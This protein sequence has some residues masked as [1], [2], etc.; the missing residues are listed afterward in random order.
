MSVSV[1]TVKPVPAA[2]LLSIF[3]PSWGKNE[4][5][6]T[7]EGAFALEGNAPDLRPSGKI[8]LKDICLPRFNLA[9]LSGTVNMPLVKEGQPQNLLG[10][11]ELP[12]MKLGGTHAEKLE[13]KL[14]IEMIGERKQEA[15]LKISDGHFQLAG[16]D[17][18]WTGVADL[19]HRMLALKGSFDKLRAADISEQLFTRAGE[20][21]GTLKGTFDLNT[22]GKTNREAIA[23]LNGKAEF[24]VENG[25]LARFGHLQ[26]ELTRVNLLHQGLFGFNLNNLLQSV[27][28]VRTGLFKEI[29]GNMRMDKGILTVEYLKYNADDMCLWAGGKANLNLDTIDLQIAGRIP[30]VSESVLSGH[31]GNMSR[32]LTLQRFATIATFG[33]LERLPSL[34][35]LGDIASDRPRTFQFKVSAPL[36]KPKMLSQSIEKSFH[37]LPVHANASAHPLPNLD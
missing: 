27:V 19:N 5:T 18:E 1:T 15:Q 26:T 20:I 33:R 34:P 6:G 8:V 30:R 31:L 21:T 37:W 23:N 14:M 28:P 2:K 10:S 17:V 7:V 25:S 12:R 11:V 36:D 35:L 24:V 3:D 4:A 22:E 16:G 13:A 29:T 9:D 32:N